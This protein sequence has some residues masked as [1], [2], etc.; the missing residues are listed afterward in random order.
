[1]KKILL[2]L[3]FLLFFTGCSKKN[4][5]SSF[6]ME[7]TQELSASSLQSSKIISKE[8]DVKGFF[9]AIYLNEV[10]PQSF[11]TNE[12]FLIFLYLKDAKELYNPQ[13]PTVSDLQLT[14]N[15]KLPIKV[16]KLPK[17]NRFSKFTKRKN[18][19]S[20]CYLVTFEPTDTLTLFLKDEHSA[21]ATTLR[22]KK[23]D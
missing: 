8:S 2:F 21:A 17:E 13:N 19:W 5:F 22:Y 15:S 23:E 9:S 10:E 18:E 1:M 12:H 20:D 7:Q 16:E 6:D 3:I 14:L 4:A 11:S